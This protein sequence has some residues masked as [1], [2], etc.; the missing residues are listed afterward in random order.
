MML[1]G[2]PLLQPPTPQVITLP[3]MQMEVP[4]ECYHQFPDWNRS[5]GLHVDG[6]K[7]CKT[8][9]HLFRFTM[10]VLWIFIDF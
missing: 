2:K 10:T 9:A 8:R 5:D 3:D 4:L 7:L 6:P 1:R